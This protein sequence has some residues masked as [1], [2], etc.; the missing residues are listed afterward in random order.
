[1]K[2]IEK[3]VNQILVDEREKLDLIKTHYVAALRRFGI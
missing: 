3:S 2:I 1:M